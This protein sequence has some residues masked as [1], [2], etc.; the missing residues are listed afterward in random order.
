MIICSTKKDRWKYDIIN[1][2]LIYFESAHRVRY[3]CKEESSH[4]LLIMY[5]DVVLTFLKILFITNPLEVFNL[6]FFLINCVIH[7]V[8]Q[9]HIFIS[10]VFSSFLSLCICVL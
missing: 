8:R 5:P 1:A 6:F 10:R 4:C 9:Y 7:N 2:F 3:V